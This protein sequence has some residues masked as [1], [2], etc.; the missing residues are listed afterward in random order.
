MAFDEKQARRIRD[1]LPKKGLTE[2]VMMGGIAFMVNG[3][4][5]CGLDDR[6]LAVRVGPDGY[7]KALSLPG[8]REFDKTGKPLRGF[9]SV[10]LA[11]VKQRGE[12]DAWLKKGLDF[13]GTLPPKRPNAGKKR[14]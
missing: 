7:E 6:E 4:M 8:A 9:V 1:L 13:V 2:R 14:K 11:S 10:D 5:C 12:L 3:H